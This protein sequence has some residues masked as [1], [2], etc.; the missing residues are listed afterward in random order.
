M[1]QSDIDDMIAVL[2]DDGFR[3]SARDIAFCVLCS[4]ID[5][6]ELAYGLL[7]GDKGTSERLCST[8][9]FQALEAYY[10]RMYGAE[11]MSYDEVK[12]GLE[13]DLAD[14]DSFVRHNGSDLDAKEMAALMGRKADLRVKLVEKFGTSGKSEE[15]KIVVLNKFNDICPWCGREISVNR[16]RADGTDARKLRTVNRTPAE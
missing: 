7:Y 10:Q 11:G 5:N 15:H 13:Q 1:K 4:Q 12:R 14:L 9:D 2:A 6:R 3:V 8:P 16:N